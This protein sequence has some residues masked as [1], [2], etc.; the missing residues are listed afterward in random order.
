MTEYYLDCYSCNSTIRISKQ[1][2]DWLTEHIFTPFMPTDDEKTI[3]IRNSVYA[4]RR[5]E[6][7]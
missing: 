6:K 4:L 5:V 1:L 2:F 7:E 3:E